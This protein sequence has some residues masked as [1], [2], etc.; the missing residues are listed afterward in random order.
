MG[1]ALMLVM[2]Y[3]ALASRHARYWKDDIACQCRPLLGSPRDVRIQSQYALACSLVGGRHDAAANRLGRL[4]EK[5]PEHLRLRQDLARVLLTAGHFGKAIPHLEWLIKAG[6]NDTKSRMALASAYSALGWY[7]EV[8]VQLKAVVALEPRDMR[9]RAYLARLYEKMNHTEQA[10][11]E[12][13]ALLRLEGDR[14]RRSALHHKV[15]ALYA[16][17]GKLEEAKAESRKADA[18]LFAP[19]RDF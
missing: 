15:A 1:A 13:Q 4:V 16:K 6:P 8:E 5:H 14:M 19:S 17:V 9:A 7:S 10:A 11:A 12:Y 18:L 2:L 3:S